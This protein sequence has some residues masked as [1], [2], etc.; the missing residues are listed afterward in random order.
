MIKLF[1]KVLA[2]PLAHAADTGGNLHPTKDLGQI[3]T[4]LIDM[5]TI[6]AL[7]IAV[8]MILIAGY[9][10][11]TAGANAEQFKNGQRTITYAI[12]GLIIVFLSKG[13][14]AIVRNIVG[15]P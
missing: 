7:S 2:I 3:L 14:I 13:I 10:M 4:S 12:V 15:L 11:M 8:I 6:L 9:M 5:A 1:Y